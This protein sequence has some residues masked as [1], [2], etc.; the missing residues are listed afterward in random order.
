VTPCSLVARQQRFNGAGC[1]HLQN[2]G[3]DS[4]ALNMEAADAFQTSVPV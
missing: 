4:S 1:L 2:R 3:F